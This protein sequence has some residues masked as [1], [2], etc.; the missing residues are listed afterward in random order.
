MKA[1]V[2]QSGARSFF[3]P[4]TCLVCGSDLQPQLLCRV[5]AQVQQEELLAQVVLQ[6]LQVPGLGSAQGLLLPATA[7]DGGLRC[8]QHPMDPR[9]LGLGPQTPLSYMSWTNT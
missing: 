4:L 7:E 9:T 1:C 8:H 2:T 5:R 6:L 3:P